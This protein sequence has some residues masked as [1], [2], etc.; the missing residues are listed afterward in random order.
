MPIIVKIVE[1]NEFAGLGDVMLDVIGLTGVIAVA[2][3]SSASR[4]RC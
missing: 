1:E 4:L 3:R 2:P